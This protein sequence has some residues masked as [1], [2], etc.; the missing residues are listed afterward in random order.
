MFIIKVDTPLLE[1]CQQLVQ[2]HNFGNRYTANGNQEQ[3]LTG[4]IG[5][6]AVMQAFGLDWVDGKGGFDHGVDLMIH[7]KKIDVKTMGRTTDVKRNYTNNFLKLQDRYNTEIYIFCSYHKLKKEVTVCGWI[8]KSN[9]STNRKL[10]PKGTTRNR[11]DGT[12]FSTFSDLY[13][14]D[15]VHLN[16]VHSV[17]DLGLQIANNNPL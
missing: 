7:S 11:T 3:Q 4:I 16:D 8:D 5:Q 2:T 15:N 12:T 1:H 14:I 9:F 6:S 13:E 17:E 10:S